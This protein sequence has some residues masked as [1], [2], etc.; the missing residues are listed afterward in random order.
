MR[1]RLW[2]KRFLPCPLR[3][4]GL[5]PEAA[6]LLRR[7]GLKTIGQIMHAP[8]Q[9]FAARAGQH[10]MLRLDQALG[11][12]AEAL[13][14]RRPPPPLF[15]LRRL[16][17]PVLTM[18]AILIVT[19]ALIGDLCGQLDER[20]SG[21]RLLRLSLFGVDNRVRTVQLG[22]SRAEADAENHAAAFA[23]AAWRFARSLGRRVRL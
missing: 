2:K 23:R 7:L 17:E 9:P 14:P 19:E 16:V 4:C 20:G 6:A 1:K 5:L 3:R 22:L 12:A 15:A 10:A 13:T 21:A 18:E 11:R 8:R